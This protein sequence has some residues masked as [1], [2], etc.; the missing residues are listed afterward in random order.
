MTTT[1]SKYSALLEL[2]KI[3]QEKEHNNDDS[4]LQFGLHTND[5]DDVVVALGM[6]FS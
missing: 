5:N 1:E 4:S 2:K 6:P 3:I